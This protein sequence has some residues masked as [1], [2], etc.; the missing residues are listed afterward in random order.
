MLLRCF[1]WGKKARSFQVYNNNSI[2]L[3]EKYLAIGNGKCN[4]LY[5]DGDI[6]DLLV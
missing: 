2:L 4:A 5:L 3:N 6:A 1:T